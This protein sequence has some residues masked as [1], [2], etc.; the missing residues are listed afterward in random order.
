MTPSIKV[1]VAQDDAYRAVLAEG[2]AAM[3]NK[4]EQAIYSCEDSIE[5]VRDLYGL[6]VSARRRTA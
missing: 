2:M 3:A 4:V 5:L 1:T 6:I